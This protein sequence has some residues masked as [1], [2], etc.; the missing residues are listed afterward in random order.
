[1]SVR[2]VLDAIRQSLWFVP[3][4]WSAACG[5]A[6]LGMVAIDHATPDVASGV[7]FVFGGGPEGARGVLS[8]IAGS[9]I[10]VVGVVFSITIVALQLASSQYSPRVLRNFMRDRASQF[11]LGSFIGV[12]VYSLLVLRTVRSEADGR[13]EFVPG[14]AVTGAVLLAVV[15]VAMLIYFIHH[16]ATRMQA[17]YITAA[18]AGETLE[19]VDRQAGARPDHAD[20][21]SPSPSEVLPETRGD[22]RCRRHERLPSIRR[23]RFAHAASRTAW[24]RDPP[25]SRA[26]RMGAAARASVR[27][28][29][30]PA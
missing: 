12:F 17:S 30:S 1:M 15:A 13:E 10:T 24:P 23:N 3:A 27:G 9:M 7:P 19:E 29:G 28:V 16:I 11:T 2:K 14:L 21:V 8:A 25:R 4:I 26:R 18:V 6:A 5:A 20:E 22:S